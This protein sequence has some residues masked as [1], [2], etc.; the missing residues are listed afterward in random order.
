MALTCSMLSQALGISATNFSGLTTLTVICALSN[1]LPL[2]VIWMIPGRDEELAVASSDSVVGRANT[3]DKD[4]RSAKPEESDSTIV[5]SDEESA[6]SPVTSD[7]ERGASR[8][9]RWGHLGLAYRRATVQVVDGDSFES[10]P[11]L[12][13]YT[14]AGQDT[15]QS[16]RVRGLPSGTA[17][18]ARISG[19][20]GE[21]ASP[22]NNQW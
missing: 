2:C 12:G 1:L 4:K 17:S 14:C 21:C 3:G 6:C 22:R 11:P 18:E 9:L 10:S 20:S 8:L 7:V 16:H 13:E 5:G 19:G 15:A